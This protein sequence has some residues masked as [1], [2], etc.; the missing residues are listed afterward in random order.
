MQTKIQGGASYNP[1]LYNMFIAR[2]TVKDVESI[3]HAT[4]CTVDFDE[5]Y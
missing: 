5:Q 2:D 1:N 3:L 4:G